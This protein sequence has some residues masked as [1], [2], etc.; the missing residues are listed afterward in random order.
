[1][2]LDNIYIW[3]RVSLF[4]ILF[5]YGNLHY[6]V[7]CNRVTYLI[8][9][10]LKYK[11]FQI[12]LEDHIFDKEGNN[13]F[14]KYD[15]LIDIYS[16][17]I[18]SLYKKN[19]FCFEKKN[20]LKRIFLSYIA[21]DISINL[22]FFVRTENYFTKKFSRN[23]IFYVFDDS[24]FVENFRFILKKKFRKIN[25]LTNK[26]YY[27]KS[28]F[29]KSIFL[30]L[31]LFVNIF[32]K[33]I[34]YEKK[35]RVFQEYKK[36][37]FDRYPDAGQLFWLSKSKINF[38]DLGWFTF[39]RNFK[40]YFKNP[41]T[42]KKEKILSVNQF[43]FLEF[44]DIFKKFFFFYLKKLFIKNKTLLNFYLLEFYSKYKIEHNKRFIKNFNIKIFHYYQEPNYQSL[45]LAYACKITNS[46][47]IW[48]HWSIDQHPVYYF[49]YGFCDIFLSW[50]A[51][52]T[53]YLNAH[54]FLYDHC[55]TTGMI[56]GDNFNA[57]KNKTNK[58]KKIIVFNSTSSSENFLHS[59]FLLK[60][61]YEAI[62][63]LAK[64]NKY[65]IYIKPKIDIFYNMDINT[66][67][68]MKDLIKKKK[69]NLYSHV[70]TPSNVGNKNDLYIAWG[71]NT[72]GNIAN[73]Q[74]KNVLYFDNAKLKFH[75]FAKKKI[76]ITDELELYKKVENF[77]NKKEKFILKK[78]RNK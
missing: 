5:N 13:F 19:I 23:K 76:I 42:Q 31:T 11:V 10:L 40:S 77:F 57:A 3:H 68:K 15:Y 48:N 16:R 45:L 17:K 36:N 4:S 38:T 29:K 1:M 27:R 63:H 51:W 18:L 43:N 46:I 75:P 34:S 37:I 41:F 72:A 66:K 64:K 20:F 53:S 71:I 8:L 55:F 62:F 14:F 44:N 52:N 54:N 25:F 61:F 35:P 60:K 2:K 50:G 30:F 6:Y 12:K 24:D 21:D 74:G 73:M 67:L 58:Q 56:A 65:K 7:H 32:K 49:K 22:N 39:E 69:I 78:K 9:K 33:K 47:V 70:L 26:N 59:N 28:L